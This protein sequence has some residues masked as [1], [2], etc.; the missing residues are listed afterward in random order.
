MTCNGQDYTNRGITYLYQ[1][2]ASVQNISLAGGLDP[3]EL[4]L[5]VTGENFVN[6]THLACR[7]GGSTSSGTFLSSRLALCFV[8]RAT[9]GVVLSPPADRGRSTGNET[10]ALRPR[11]GESFSPSARLGPEDG[12]GK[13]LYVEV[14][15]KLKL[16]KIYVLR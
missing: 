4:G 8:P 13:T 14:R 15:I 7:V 9:F 5:F 11:E 16:H 12:H 2:D 10:R 6:S 3:A 1:A